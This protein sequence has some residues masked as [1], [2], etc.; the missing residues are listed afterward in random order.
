[1]IEID[2]KR[3]LVGNV[4]LLLKYFIEFLKVV[5][6]IIEIMVVCVVG[7]KYIGCII[8][9]DVLKDD[10]L[11]IVKV[12]KE[13][14]IKNIQILLGDKQSIVSIFVNKLGII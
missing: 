2:G 5:F 7:D 11:D 13:L 14:N 3:V 6:L 8:L 12:F 1:M 10:V 4:R 9:L